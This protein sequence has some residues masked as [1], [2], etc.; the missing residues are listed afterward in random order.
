MT[1]D[2]TIW[3]YKYVQSNFYDIGIALLVYHKSVIDGGEIGMW[4]RFL[5]LKITSTGLPK[6]YTSAE[7]I[8]R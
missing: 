8:S 5:N 2:I 6:L 4:S 3:S 7:I 1:Y